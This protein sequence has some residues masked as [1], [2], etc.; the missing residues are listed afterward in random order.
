MLHDGCEGGAAPAKGQGGL[1]PAQAQEAFE[2]IGGRLESGVLVLCDH[3]SNRIPPEF[4]AL[5]LPPGELERHIAWDIGAAGVARALAARLG[6]PA[7]LGRFSRLLIDPNRGLDD[8]TLV[9]RLSDGAII[10]GNATIDMAE[11]RR[12][13]ARFYRPYDEAISRAVGAFRAAGME[14]ALVSIHSFTPVWRGVRR[15]WHAGLLYD[16]RDPDFSVALMEAL[17]REPGLVIG[18]NQP[19]RGGLAGD[20]MDRHGFARGLAHA[21]VEVRQDLIAD[22][23]G[24][25]EWAGRIAAATHAALDATGGVREYEGKRAGAD[26]PP[27]R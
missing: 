12:R 9:M 2:V 3:A 26:S 11:K 24:Q 8:P 17:R 6:A 20:T 27:G 21:L 13:I 14:P 19:Y 1:L 25:E 22:A 7:V 23:R 18:D 4:S 5:G 10:P 15:P 16:P